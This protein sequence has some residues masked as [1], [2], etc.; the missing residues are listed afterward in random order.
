M[1][2]ATYHAVNT[3]ALQAQFA[4]DKSKQGDSAWLKLTQGT[5]TL[6]IC[7]PFGP[8]GIPYRKAES[9][10]NLV[11]AENRKINPVSFDY[12][13]GSKKLSTYMAKAKKIVLD[14]PKSKA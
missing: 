5:H 7:P 14:V 8:D 3:E 11:G 6:R 13:F 10:H 2:Q 9:F 1:T 12:L 4:E